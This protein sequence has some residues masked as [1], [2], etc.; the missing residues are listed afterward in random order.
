MCDGADEKNEEKDEGD[1]EENFYLEVGEER[2]VTTQ[3][4][5]QGDGVVVKKGKERETKSWGIVESLWN[6]ETEKRKDGACRPTSH[7]GKAEGFVEG[8]IEKGKSVFP[9]VEINQSEGERGTKHYGVDEQKNEKSFFSH[10]SS[11]V[12]LLSYHKKRKKAREE[13]S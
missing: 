12:F 6:I 7:T 1:E 8:T 4:G 2:I 3:E 13:N 9:G 11:L 5:N 10:K